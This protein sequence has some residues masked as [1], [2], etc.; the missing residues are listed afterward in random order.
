MTE[1][2]AFRVYDDRFVHLFNGDLHIPMDEIGT[3]GVEMMAQSEPNEEVPTV[4]LRRCV[5]TE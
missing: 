5:C 4:D 2:V 3:R 1:A